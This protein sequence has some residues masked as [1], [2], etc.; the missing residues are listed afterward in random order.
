MSRCCGGR[1]RAGGGERKKKHDGRCRLKA[2]KLKAERYFLS[3][4]SLQDYPY[5]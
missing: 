1:L 4:D 5:Q 2:L 3:H